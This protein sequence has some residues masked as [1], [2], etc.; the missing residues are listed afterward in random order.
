M[1]KWVILAGLVWAGLH[2]S[3]ARATA[4]FFFFFFFFALEDLKGIGA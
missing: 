4:V 1:S 2:P 3:M